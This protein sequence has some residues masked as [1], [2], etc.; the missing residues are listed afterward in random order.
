[1]ILLFLYFFG[2]YLFDLYFWPPQGLNITTILIFFFEMPYI[3]DYVVL[4]TVC[5]YLSNLG[6]RFQI[7]NDLWKCLPAGL[8]PVPDKWTHFDIAMAV[9]NIRLLHAELCEL[10]KT[11]DSG[12]GPLLLSFFVCTFID[13]IYVFYLMLYHEFISD[14]GFIDSVLK[15]LAVHIFNVQVVIFTISIVASASWANEKVNY[16]LKHTYY[17]P[18]IITVLIV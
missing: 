13:M 3:T 15:Y 17:A 2:Y 1:M 5:Y 10:L 7:L 9:E 8:A 4:V 14:D 16:T 18:T 6:C 11:F 12:F